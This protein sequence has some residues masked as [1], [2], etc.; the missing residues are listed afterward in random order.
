M[1]QFRLFPPLT[2]TSTTKDN[3]PSRGGRGRKVLVGS[4]SPSTSTVLED[5]RGSRK[6]DAVLR[7]IGENAKAIQPP[8]PPPKAH[9]TK[10]ALKSDIFGG[11]NGRDGER[12]EPERLALSSS[13]TLADNR[14]PGR[15]SALSIPI[16]S[17]FPRYNPNL[18]L[19]EQE[20]YPQISDSN[21]RSRQKPK[22]LVLSPEP[23]IDRA[24]GPKTVP[25]SVMEFLPG[26]L[27]SVEVHYSSAIDLQ[28]LWEAANGQRLENQT[29]S[30]KLRLTRTDPTTFTFSDPQHQHPFYTLRLTTPAELT[31]SRTNP[32]K[33]TNSIPIMT[34][35]LKD[36]TRREHPND[37]LV[38][39]VSS[40][41]AA[42]LA[43]EQA[44][45][46]AR[47]QHL[48]P[49]E[50][51]DAQRKALKRAEEQ[52]SCRLAWNH[53]LRLYTLEHPSFSKQATP[54][55]I[56]AAGIPLSPARPKGPGAVHITVS[57]PSPSPTHTTKQPQSQPST[58]LA[59][60]PTPSNSTSTGSARLA[61]T[62][63][64]SM[65]PLTDT[66]DPLASLDL[67]TRTLCI[68]SNA[69][70]AT[71]PSLYAIDS[72]VAGILAVAVVDEGSRGVLMGMEMGTG[73]Q[74]QG[75]RQELFTTV[76]EREDVAMG[77][78]LV[79][80]FESGPN[81]GAVN[82]DKQEPSNSD[83]KPP[84]WNR[85]RK[86]RPQKP[87]QK[88]KQIVI[89]EFDL[90]KYGRY[91]PSSSREGEKLPSIARGVLRVLFWGLDLV[92]KM[93]TAMVKM[94]AWILVNLTR[95]VTSERF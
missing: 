23:E 92:V 49:S 28:G 55:L 64:T 61:P 26:L 82:D 90:E 59:T 66:D 76:A 57:T 83:T 24:L 70:I 69:V 10:P 78:D 36:R 3:L 68:S 72:V 15:F 74:N 44:D 25:A 4:S 31:I 89:E 50:A 95:C 85:L 6:T 67:S 77:C 18:P 14:S 33:P 19:S 11:A 81:T 80:R 12:Q 17:I 46:V 37:G 35:A 5:L 73:C 60:A 79:E 54:D 38:S 53:D 41:L 93:L 84:F 52:E 29:A 22:G 34:L 71:I 20:Y 87:K 45:E 7:Q 39:I 9:V 48:T 16:K 40:R 30:F 42:M 51:L 47:K 91:G 75:T 32:T 62:P 21:S 86:P 65:L 2:P 8:K 63:R 94:L 56:S 27:D 58:I 43:V 88:N 1:S 13:S